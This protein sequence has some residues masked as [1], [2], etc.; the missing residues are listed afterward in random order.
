MSAYFEN[1][2]RVEQLAASLERWHGTP[3]LQ[4]HAKPGVGVDCVR[5]VREVFRECGVDVSSA[6]DLPRYGLS[7]GIHQAESQ[8]LAWL[9]QE[10][11]LRKRFARPEPRE[12]WI[13]G[14]ILAVRRSLS[15]H[16]VG[17]AGADTHEVWHV[18][19]PAGVTRIDWE[20]AR[21][22]LEIAGIFRLRA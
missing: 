3:F 1:E 19:I 14:D 17:I 21:G 13:P 9:L 4:H 20:A 11:S 15:V 22:H 8:V 16:H 6:E 7:W 12:P 2:E 18:D 5:F 10:R